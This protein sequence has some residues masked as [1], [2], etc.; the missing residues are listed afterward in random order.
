MDLTTG[1]ANMA[2]EMSATKTGFEA[3]VSVAKKA[4]D[5]QKQTGESVL[6][7]IESGSVNKPIEGS[8]IG[9]NINLL[10]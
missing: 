7:L 1:I 10:A 3:N 5:V 6:G 8:T 4:L 9:S 2:T